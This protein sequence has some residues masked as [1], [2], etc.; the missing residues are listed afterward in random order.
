MSLAD[1]NAYAKDTEQLC[2]DNLIER[3]LRLNMHINSQLC[4]SPGNETDGHA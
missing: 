3:R 1:S 4:Y 2:V